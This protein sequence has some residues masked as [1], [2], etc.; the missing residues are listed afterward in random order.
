MRKSGL[1]ND[2]AQVWLEAQL[3]HE[4]V[5]ECLDANAQKQVRD[6]QENLERRRVTICAQRLGLTQ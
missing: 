3:I 6:K 2:V 1:P 5:I 4:N